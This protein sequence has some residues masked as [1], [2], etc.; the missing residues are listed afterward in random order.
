MTASAAPRALLLG[1]GGCGLTHA[2]FSF[3]WAL[4]GRWL[5]DTV[6]QAAVDAAHSLPIG[7]GATLGIAGL[8]KAAGAVVPLLAVT[9]R[10]W[11]PALWRAVAL[12]G[13]VLLVVYGGTYMAASWAV[14]LGWIAVPGGYDRT[15]HMGHA[16]LWDPLFVL[17]GLLL[18]AGLWLHRRASRSASGSP[19][20]GPPVA[21][22]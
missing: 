8:M 15:A 9:G 1:A 16:V 19:D 10:V 13:G 14:L 12:A 18:V 17:W 6:G 20:N 21:T 4:G 7:A 22:R 5:L 2:A 3:Y 11:R